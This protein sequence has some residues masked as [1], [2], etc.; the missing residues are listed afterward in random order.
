MIKSYISKRKK[1]ADEI[2]TINAYKPLSSTTNTDNH[3]LYQQTLNLN[4]NKSTDKT[5]LKNDKNECLLEQRPINTII[6]SSI[7]NF[8]L[9][10]ADPLS[11]ESNEYYCNQTNYNNNTFNNE[12]LILLDNISNTSNNINDSKIPIDLKLKKWTIE[13]NVPHVTINKLLSIL[14]EENYSPFQKFPLDSRTLLQ[15][16]SSKTTNIDILT[17]GIYYHFGLKVGIINSSLKFKLDNEIEVI[18]GVDGLPLSKSSSS[19]FWSIL[20]YIYPHSREG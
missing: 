5:S 4:T 20:A 19:Q 8:S 12:L 16:G 10:N 3:Q 15:S 2:S 9:I 6:D 14:K 1:I 13:C 17:P 7:Q 11:I 18:V